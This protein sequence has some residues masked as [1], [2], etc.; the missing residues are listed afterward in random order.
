MVAEQIAA[1][2]VSDPR[3]LS[4]MRVVPRHLFVP[5][6]HDRNAYEDCPLPIGHGQ[7]IS[8]PYIVGLMTELLRTRPSDHILEIGAGCGY[9]A[10]VLSLLVQKVTTIERVPAVA[11]LAKKNLSMEHFTN[12]HVIVGDGTKGYPPD[13]PYNGIIITASTPHIPAPLIDQLADGG[14][15]VAPVGSREIQELVVMEK[16]GATCKQ[17]HHGGVRFV[18]LIGE[19]GWG[20]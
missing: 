16:R 9:Q 3:V 8:Q 11:E 2:G 10:A 13:A 4:A 5:P 15:I 12:V 17:E 20:A 14:R 7:T 6:P 18:P 19:H 1:R